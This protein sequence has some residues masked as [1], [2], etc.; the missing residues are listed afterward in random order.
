MVN[1]HTEDKWNLPEALLSPEKIE[2]AAAAQMELALRV[3]SPFA[4]K[5]S[6]DIQRFNAGILIG[7]TE[8][9]LEAI[10]LEDLHTTAREQYAEA[11]AEV[12]NFQKAAEI[13]KDDQRSAHYNEIWKAVWLDDD[14]QC[15]CPHQVFANEKRNNLFAEAEVWS[16]K[17]NREMS[18]V[19]C[20]SCGHRNVRPLP[21]SIRKERELRKQNVQ[22]V[23]GRSH[24][25]AKQILI[26]RRR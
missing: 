2:E 13:T 9:L 17:H 21:D 6:A 10:P 16:P 8:K 25:E 19:K 5:T 15:E 11:L 26:A 4:N 12:G 22:L 23:S 3:N 1:D 18:V 20:T 7:E 14:E 24:E